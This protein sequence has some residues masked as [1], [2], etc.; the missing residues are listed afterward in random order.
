MVKKMSDKQRK[1]MFANMRSNTFKLDKDL[2]LPRAQNILPDTP[3]NRNAWLKEGEARRTKKPITKSSNN[4]I[5]PSQNLSK[6]AG[7][8]AMPIILSSIIGVPIPNS[9]SNAAFDSILDSYEVYKEKKNIDDAFYVGVE[10]FVKNYARNS[11]YG[12]LQSHVQKRTDDDIFNDVLL[13]TIL[14]SLSMTESY[15]FHSSILCNPELH[16]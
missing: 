16:A 6:Y 9:V 5:I 4:K 11:G 15:F 3:T 8:Q 14:L 7:R 1:A 2:Q 13:G 12:Y 10:S